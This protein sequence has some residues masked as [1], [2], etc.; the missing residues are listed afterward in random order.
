MTDTTPDTSSNKLSV[1]AASW[2]RLY[3]PT[4]ECVALCSTPAGILSHLATFD[5]PDFPRKAVKGYTIRRATRGRPRVVWEEGHEDPKTG[6]PQFLTSM[7]RPT[8]LKALNR[9]ARVAEDEA[10]RESERY[11]NR[12]ARAERRKQTP[13]RTEGSK[14]PRAHKRTYRRVA[15]DKR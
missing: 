3:T 8:A 2:F 11:A 10:L 14:K 5:H 12:K 13:F 4:G 15:K 7:P 1:I 9:A 6:K